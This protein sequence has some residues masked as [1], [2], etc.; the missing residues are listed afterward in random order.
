MRLADCATG[1]YPIDMNVD[2]SEISDRTRRAAAALA[3]EIGGARVI[4]DPDLL[5]GAAGDE[6]VV[7]PRTPDALVRVRSADEIVSV[8]R[9]AA[10]FE[11]PVTPRG[12][13]TGKAGGAVPAFGGMVLDTSKMNRIL[14]VDREN[15]TAWVEPGVVT[16]V[17]Q[18][19]MDKLG[20]FYPPDPN[21]LETCCLGGNAAH[22]AGGPRAYKYG[23][24]RNFVMGM[25]TVLM[26]G[27]ILSTGRGTVK[28]AAGYDLTG[29]MVGSEGTLSVFSKL[30]LSLIHKPQFVVTALV[31]FSDEASAGR[32]TARITAAGIRP[33]VLEY[34]DRELV[35]IVRQSGAD[36]VPEGTAALLLAELDGDNE[37]AL[38]SELDQLA[39]LCDEEGAKDILIAKHGSDREGLWSA[40]RTLSDAVKKRAR[41]KI[42]E[43]VAVPASRIP[44][45]LDGLKKLSDTHGLLIASYGH[46]GD[47]NY[48][49][50]VLWDDDDLDPEPAVA[51]VLKL[52]VS[53]DGTITGE[54]GVGLAK[55]KYLPLQKTPGQIAWMKRTKA[56]FDPKGLLNPGK[57]F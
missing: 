12:G 11:V 56:L 24:T 38:E 1:C 33:R 43:D 20:L 45:L 52:A 42:S 44:E 49:V 32:A 8:L 6:S 50:N 31:L 53:L 39:D 9:I 37:G 4:E 34:M 30:R 54:H 23:V 29:T 16:G 21:S 41:H 40:R 55:K 47:G 28:C 10:A 3:K 25:E 5:V 26:G 46:A 35:A 15:L 18:D 27:E 48:H 57:I 22:N 36:M 7:P 19:E 2:S 51:G 13:G 14:G 17:F